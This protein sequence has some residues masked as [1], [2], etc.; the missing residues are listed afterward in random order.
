[1][2]GNIPPE[3]FSGITTA[4]TWTVLPVGE[5]AF[6]RLRAVEAAGSPFQSAAWLQA[7]VRSQGLADRFRLLD[8]SFAD[9]SWLV[10]PLQ[11]DFV[12]GL[13]VLG[14]IGG[15]HASFF[16]PAASRQAIP[17]D[18]L[19]GTFR[20]IAGAEGIDALTLADCPVV[21]AGSPHPLLTL[22]HR[23][24]PSDAAFL[25]LDGPAE[26]LMARLFDREGLKKQ[27]YKRRK[28]AEIGAIAAGWASC[29]T[30]AEAALDQF[31][32]WKARQFLSM[33]VPDPFA[34]RDVKDFLFEAVCGP[35]G[36]I[37]LF[38]LTLEGRPVAVIGVARCGTHASGMFTAYD[39]SPD[40]ARFSPGDVAMGELVV[41]LRQ[42]GCTGFDL[43]IGEA[44]YKN[45]FCPET[46]PIVD[47]AEGFTLRGQLAAAAW[48]ALRGAKRVIKRNP[49]LFE[50][51]KGVRRR[52]PT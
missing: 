24:A 6:A 1:M 16:A 35:E 26:D 23:P 30:S 15:A 21:W 20:E 4:C 7:L 10:L 5:D 11:H 19:R 2:I 45:Q 42:E 27:R 31:F 38:T 37:R 13:A 12:H 22:D 36:A 14:K 47:I 44:R 52:L 33:G 3:R 28:F 39:P 18:A 43:G 34:A 17:A 29:E 50:L 32:D 48:L 49:K 8:L 40:I 46:L 25:H 41:A 51:A 9:G